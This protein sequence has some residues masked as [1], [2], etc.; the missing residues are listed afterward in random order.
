MPDEI[1]HLE[2]NGYHVERHEDV[3]IIGKARQMEG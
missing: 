1:K 2:D 3:D